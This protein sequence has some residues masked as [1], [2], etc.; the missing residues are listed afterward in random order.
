M[1]IKHFDELGGLFVVTNKFFE[2]SFEIQDTS[3]P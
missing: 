3:R 2:N 1:L